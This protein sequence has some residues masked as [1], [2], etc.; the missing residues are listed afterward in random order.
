[1][2]YYKRYRVIFAYNIDSKV[3]IN[4][5]ATMEIIFCNFLL[6]YNVRKTQ[7]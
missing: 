2:S 4:T 6:K 1:M 7:Q 3:E 5:K